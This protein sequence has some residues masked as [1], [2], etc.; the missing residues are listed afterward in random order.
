MELKRVRLEDKFVSFIH[1]LAHCTF[2]RLT[3]LIIMQQSRNDVAVK[4]V[5]A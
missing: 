2:L 3:L 4:Q 5:F 1:A